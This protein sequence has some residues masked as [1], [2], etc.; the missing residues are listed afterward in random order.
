LKSLYNQPILS[1]CAV[2]KLTDQLVWGWA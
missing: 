1:V 2:A